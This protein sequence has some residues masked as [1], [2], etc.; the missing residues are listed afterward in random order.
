MLALPPF[1]L[2]LYK[3]YLRARLERCTRAR[4]S[5]RL[6]AKTIFMPNASCT[7]KCCRCARNCVL[8]EP[9]Q[10]QAPPRCSDALSVWFSVS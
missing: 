10:L 3:A 1:A 5:S 4:K 2:A 8:C 7:A 6:S 9:G